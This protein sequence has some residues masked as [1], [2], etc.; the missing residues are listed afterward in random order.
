MLYHIIDDFFHSPTVPTLIAVLLSH[1]GFH[2]SLLPE[3]L[4]ESFALLT[5]TLHSYHVFINA[6]HVLVNNV[7]LIFAKAYL[8]KTTFKN[9]IL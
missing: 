8:V 7:P 5:Q 1:L 3:L 6:L 2:L 4:C 9:Q